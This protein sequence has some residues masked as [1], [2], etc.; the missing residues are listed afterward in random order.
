MKPFLKI[1]ADDIYRKFNGELADIAIVF[2]NKRAGLFFNEYLLQ[3]SNRPLWSPVYMTISELFEQCSDAVKGDS[4]LLVSKL[5]KEY[6]KHTH[7][8]E[9]ID[10]FYYWGEMMIKDFDDIDKNLVDADMLFSNLSSLRAMGS[11][12]DTLDEEQR[13]AVE[14]FFI[15]FKP[16]ERSEM[17]RRFLATWEV[18]GDIYKS[19][20]DTLHNEGIA[21]EGM[22]YRDV[23]EKAQT[24][25]FPH[26][27]YIFIGFNALNRVEN[28]LFATMQ[29]RGKALFYWD[30]DVAYIQNPRHEAAHFMRRNLEC[31]PNEP[32]ASYFNNLAGRQ[33]DIVATSTDS[34]QMRYASEWIRKNITEREVE[35]AVI[36]C[37]ESRLE[38]ICHTIPPEVHDINVTMGYP[39]SNTPV[40]NLM[41][42]LTDLQTNGY[43]AAHGTFTLEAVHS[44]LTHPY[45]LHN[46]PEARRIDREITGKRLFFP[47]IA[48]LHADDF[49]A[50]LFTR[51][52]D[53]VLW[54]TSLADI[55]HRIAV[56]TGSGAGAESAG[57][58]MYEELFREALLKT[59]TQLQR[60]IA[61]I[62]N[63]ELAMQ[64]STLGNLLMRVLGSA[65]MPFHGEP[66]MGMQVM[67]L[68]ETRNLDFRNIIF[69]SANEGN[70]P[71]TGSESS[72]V[73]YNLRRAFGMTLS[74]HRDSIYA[75]NFYRLLQRAEKVTILYND[76]TDS[77]N[78]GECSRYILQ[79]QADGLCAGKSTV[80]TTQRNTQRTPVPVAKTPAM[81][82]RLLHRYDTR[83]NNKA[84][85]LSP[86]AINRYLA[87]PLSFFYR[88]VMGLKAYEEV[89]VEI[90]NNDFG[91]VFH[92]AA[93]LFYG[94]AERDIEKS[95]I[96]PYIDNDT[97]LYPFIDEAFKQTFFNG[98]KPV[99]DGEQYINREVLF[100]F[101]KR[102]VRMDAEH[103]PFRYIGSEKELDFLRTVKTSH[104][105][106]TLRIG[107]RADRIDLKD[108]TL[109]IVDYKTGGSQESPASLADV[110][111]HEGKHPGYIFQ[112][113][114]YSVAA[115]ERGMAKQV[116]PSLLYIHKK[117]TA[118]R[119]D[120]IVK[121]AGVPLHDAAPLRNE[122]NT[123]LD[124]K[125]QEIFDIATP[126]RPTDNPTRC[127]FCDF[128]KICGR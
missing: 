38:S 77:A 60:L 33:V 105:D 4:I 59:Y 88:Y 81:M 95:D 122:F 75:Y 17:K 3:N 27:K 12:A 84:A 16:E 99:Y 116:S 45:I 80:T 53:N 7:S 82:E 42:L 10:R 90:Q 46:S 98:E 117:A 74:E 78:R 126:F 69:L 31:F 103:A 44:L 94:N 29:E 1:A 2:P 68:L 58:D 35:T 64:Q 72:F 127:E 66:V 106:V 86:S 114:L 96:A 52:D 23:M 20:R 110:F 37:D 85:T 89:T 36:L 54:L 92:K 70:L 34:V 18:M 118:K 49:L 43:D 65:S 113:L 109:E 11:A 111:A 51:R 104:G 28:A 107:G 14:Q 30:Y 83:T 9:S 100:R 19:F 128:K 93:E 102:L 48:L 112:A 40:Y 13:R 115:I 123:L 91:N 41:R 8:D 22:L 125:L 101:L 76:T 55:I 87:C 79:L 21:Y 61:I 56:N 25:V 57:Y 15:N 63:G 119:S 24:I 73:P 5:Y 6:R 121:I 124:A 39:L 26:R 32:D 108:D 47:P 71:K 97:R 67:G 50:T 62:G 120:F